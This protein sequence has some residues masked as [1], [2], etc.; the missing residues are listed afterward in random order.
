M[1]TK[2]TKS[3]I[4]EETAFGTLALN[5]T[6]PSIGRLFGFD[7]HNQRLFLGRTR[8]PPARTDLFAQLDE[9][10]LEHRPVLGFISVSQVLT[11][12]DME[13]KDEK[14]N[15]RVW[16]EVSRLQKFGVSQMAPSATSPAQFELY[17]LPSPEEHVH[18]ERWLR[19]ST[20]MADLMAVALLTAAG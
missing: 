15:P 17:T 14:S 12:V 2:T 3:T 4:Y 16:E 9:V 6:K 20:S 7:S 5:R 13:S 11:L 10:G 1:A 19:R 18:E 8:I